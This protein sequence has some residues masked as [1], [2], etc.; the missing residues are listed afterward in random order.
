MAKKPPLLPWAVLFFIQALLAIAAGEVLL[1]QWCVAD[2]QTTDD[3]L[4]AALDWACGPDGGNCSLIQPGR[5]CFVPNSLK[6]HASYAFNSYWQKFKN[7]GGS[8]YFSGAAVVTDSD[9]SFRS[10]RLEFIP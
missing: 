3:A 5:P 2:E 1:R 4:Q 10:C 7:K 6:S 8:C 9:P